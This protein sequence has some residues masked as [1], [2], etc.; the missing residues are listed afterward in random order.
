MKE[1]VISGVFIA[2]LSVLLCYLGGP[3]L[4]T[5]LCLLSV[6][7]YYE[8]T[9]ALKVSDDNNKISSIQIVSII[10]IVLYYLI[11]FFVNDI[12]IL[13]LDIMLMFI[14]SCVLYVV[15]YPK[16]HSRQVISSFFSFIYGAVML[17]FVYM[18][19]SVN[20]GDNLMYGYNMGFYFVWF[21]IISA[22]FSDTGAY[23]VGVLIGKHKIFPRLSPKKTIE[24]C[25]GGVVVTIIGFVLYGLLLV[26][27]NVVDETAVVLMGC[28][29]LIGS[30]VAQIGDLVA[31]A[32]KR[33]NDIKDYGKL[34]PGH[35][36]IMDR[37]DSIIFVS[38]MIYILCVLMLH[39]M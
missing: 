21:I 12:E 10:G 24:G 29:G 34:I 7:A 28:L 3:F 25:L 4:A 38:P 36:G 27:F 9:K 31:S 11:L 20:N 35:G 13:F 30:V 6:I 37:F 33:N 26:H 23:F 16:Y 14:V 19:R 5:V 15:T 1:R 17:S 18:V 39:M 22:W 8:L 32:I 2:L